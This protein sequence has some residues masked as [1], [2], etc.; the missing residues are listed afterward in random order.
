V[1]KLAWA[2]IIIGGINWGLVGFGALFFGA[3]INLVS[4]IFG[5][6]TVTYVIYL[7][8]GVSAVY[9]LLGYCGCKKCTGMSCRECSNGKCDV[10]KKEG[11]M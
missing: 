9:A 2:L 1:K 10:H 8:V 7:L 3:E 6:S 5:T 11:Q 4:M